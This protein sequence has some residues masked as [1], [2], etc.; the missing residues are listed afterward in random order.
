MAFGAFV[1]GNT[2][3]FSSFSK[4]GNVKINDTFANVNYYKFIIVTKDA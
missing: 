2:V 4:H 3:N 1:T